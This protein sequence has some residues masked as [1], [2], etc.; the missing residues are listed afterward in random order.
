MIISVIPAEYN[1]PGQ[2]LTRKEVKDPKDLEV[3]RTTLNDGLIKNAQLEAVGDIL[4]KEARGDV[5]LSS[6]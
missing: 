4:N 1:L 5:S 2:L 3:T 6:R